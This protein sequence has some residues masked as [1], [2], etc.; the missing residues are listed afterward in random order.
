VRFA[1]RS[2]ERTGG[3]APDILPNLAGSLPDDCVAGIL[4]LPKIWIPQS[5]AGCTR[6]APDEHLLV[7]LAREALGLMAGLFWDIGAADRPPGG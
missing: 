3:R 2:L 1:A 5:H 6:H 7:P 4:G